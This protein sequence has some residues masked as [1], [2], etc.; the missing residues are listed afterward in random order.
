M[1]ISAIIP[2][3]DRLRSLRRVLPT[4]LS[5]PETDEVIV[6]VDGS[7]DGT[8]EYLREAA[9]GD[10]RIRVMDNGRNRGIPYSKNRGIDAAR[11][12]FVFIGEDDV[13]LTDHF[14]RTLLEHR[15]ATGADVI[16]GRNIWRYERESAEGA[17]QRA[18]QITGPAVN[19]RTMAIDTSVRLD[20]DTEQLLLANPMLAPTEIFLRVRYDERYR[21]NAWREE[22]DFQITAQELGYRLVSCPHAICFNYMLEN[23][24]GGVY[25]RIGWG[26]LYWVAV[27]NWRFIRKHPEFIAEHFAVGNPAVFEVLTTMRTFRDEMLVPRLVQLKRAMPGRTRRNGDRT[28]P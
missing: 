25:A 6:V 8:V 9:R 1:S 18:D 3:K 20:R 5:Q 7:R 17:I 15:N 12:D 14:F 27:N 21:V 16:C 4:Y 23:D 10:P 11:S 28:R 22:S 19:L 24:R 13:E 2:T 26:R